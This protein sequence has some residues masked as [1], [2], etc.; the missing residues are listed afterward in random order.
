LKIFWI[1]LL[2]QQIFLRKV[3]PIP[4]KDFPGKDFLERNYSRKN[5][6]NPGNSFIDSFKYVAIIQL[7]I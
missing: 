6:I 2:A 3:N 1:H 7:I 4:G 5:P